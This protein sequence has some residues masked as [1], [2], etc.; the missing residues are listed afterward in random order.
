MKKSPCHLS[1]LTA[2]LVLT[3]SLLVPMAC[4]AEQASDYFA[5]T[6]AVAY[7]EAG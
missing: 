5:V 4:A 6:E 7:A 3:L 1:C 2:V